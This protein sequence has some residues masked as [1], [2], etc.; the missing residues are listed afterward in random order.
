MGKLDGRSVLIT[1]AARGQGA[2]IARLFVEEGA[3]VVLTDIRDDE[4]KLLADELGEQARYIH[5][6]VRRETDWS[7][8]VRYTDAEFGKL[9]GL[10]NNAGVLHICTIEAD[11]RASFLNVVE[12]NQLGVFLG[13]KAVIRSMRDAG[14]GTIVNT[15]SVD[16]T[17]G[18]PMANAYCASKFAVVGM[19]KVA[20][21]ELGRDGIRVNAI[22]PGVIITDMV[23]GFMD[24]MQDILTDRIPLHRFGRPAEIASV[25]LFL[26]SDD[27]SY[28]TGANVVVDGGWT[29]EV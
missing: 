22:S 16:G 8:A 18:V 1:G 7:A 28:C 17:N 29:A 6:D 26:T 5:L 9:D 2:A 21:I 27:S 4:G 3:R 23:S 25:A 15:A 10:I 13:M 20:A 19:T 24:S 11:S 12:I 14:G